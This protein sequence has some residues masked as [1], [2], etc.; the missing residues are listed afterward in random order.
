MGRTKEETKKNNGRSDQE[1][2]YGWDHEKHFYIPRK[3]ISCW[4]RCLPT[5]RDGQVP[6]RI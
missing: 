1:E 2:E 4:T 5:L 6:L 3:K